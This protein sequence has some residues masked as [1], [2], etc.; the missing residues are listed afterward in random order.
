V[1]LFV[2]LPSIRET[3]P[4]CVRDRR[5]A[6]AGSC[7]IVPGDVALGRRDPGDVRRPPSD[8]GRTRRDQRVRVPPPR[9]ENNIIPELLSGYETGIVP[10]RISLCA[11]RVIPRAVKRATTPRGSK[12]LARISLW[13][14]GFAPILRFETAVSPWRASALN[15]IFPPNREQNRLREKRINSKRE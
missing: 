15:P 3:R 1:C 5:S 9:R 2:Y 6:A 8:S 13:P 14:N 12:D 4:G 11:D 7:E 10:L